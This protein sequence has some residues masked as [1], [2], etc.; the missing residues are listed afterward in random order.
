MGNTATT[1]PEQQH[2]LNEIKDK[3]EQATREK[4]LA[5]LDADERVRE[6][7]AVKMIRFKVGFNKMVTGYLD[8]A[9]KVKDIKVLIYL[10]VAVLLYPNFIYEL[11]TENYYPIFKRET[12]VLLEDTKS[13]KLFLI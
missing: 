6:Q 9:E 12:F 5:K 3:L 2:Q 7:E 11:I 10:T 4:E 8:L 1:P 13:S